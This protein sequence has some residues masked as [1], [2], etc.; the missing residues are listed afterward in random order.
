MEAG[1][2]GDKS[3]LNGWLNRLLRYLPQRSPIQAL[4]IGNTTP[5][6]LTGPATVAHLASGHPATRR[7]PL[8]RP[9]VQAAFDRLYSGNDALSRAYQDG[10]QARDSLMADLN[11][12]MMPASQGAP[13]PQHFSRD[14]QHLVRLYRGNS[15]PQI[16]F[17]ALGGWD[18]HTNQGSS[19]GQLAQQLQ[20]LG[21]GL[22][23]LVH[24]LGPLFADTTIVVMSGVWPHRA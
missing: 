22:V 15:Q 10:R 21:Q 6:I 19:Q 12:E 20:P 7:L 8:D 16:A 23:Q 18:T 3:T 1:T 4:N 14:V 17:L 24:D 9:A 11:D 5:F 2:P 13:T